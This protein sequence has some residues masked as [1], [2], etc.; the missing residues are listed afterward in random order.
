MNNYITINFDDS[1]TVNTAYTQLKKLYPKSKIIMRSE[2]DE[3]RVKA[4]L[5]EA[6]ESEFKELGIKSEDEFMDWINEVIKET[7]RERRQ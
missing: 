4:E 1:A 2:E 5:Q 3:K 6:M 7:R